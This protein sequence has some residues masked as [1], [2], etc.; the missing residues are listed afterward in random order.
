[1]GRGQRRLGTDPDLDRSILAFNRLPAG[2]DVVRPFR[3]TFAC[4]RANV[5]DTGSNAITRPAGPTIDAASTVKVPM[6]APMSTTVAP[7]SRRMP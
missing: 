2:D 7:G 1:M 5:A 4:R 3:A 6:L